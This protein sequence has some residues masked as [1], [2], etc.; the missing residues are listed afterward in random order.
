MLRPKCLQTPCKRASLAGK[1]NRLAI[2]EGIRQRSVA[3][4]GEPQ[5]PSLARIQHKPRPLINVPGLVPI[6][7]TC[8]HTRSQAPSPAQHPARLRSRCAAAPTPG[9]QASLPAPGPSLTERIFAEVDA[10]MAAENAQA[11]GAGGRTTYAAFKAADEQW[12]KLR[13]Q[14]VCETRSRGI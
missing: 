6:R 5:L 4:V 14:P 11:A 7:R 2:R 8:C 3:A 1:N 9:N 13:T 12:L 10:L